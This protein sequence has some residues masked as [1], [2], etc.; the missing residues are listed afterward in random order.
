LR[1]VKVEDSKRGRKFH[2]VNVVAGQ[3][4]DKNGICKI[5]PMC[6]QK[7][8]NAVRFEEWV[9]ERL[10][11]AVK[12]GST[13]IMDNARFHRKNELEKIMKEAKVHLL[14][15]PPYSPDLNPIEKLWANMKRN[16]QDTAPLYD[17]LQT[18]IY[19]YLC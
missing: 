12:K 15:L 5:A 19:N 4:K 17:L 16:L 6:Y 8:M 11:P 1:G 14:F 3:T 9:K 18:A 2:R 7:A 10:L 13:I